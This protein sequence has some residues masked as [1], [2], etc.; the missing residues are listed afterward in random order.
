[1]KVSRKSI[2]KNLIHLPFRHRN[3]LDPWHH[4][5]QVRDSRTE[6]RTASNQNHIDVHLLPAGGG[7]LHLNLMSISKM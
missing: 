5:L 4:H 2:K 1:M 7:V 3:M 6:I